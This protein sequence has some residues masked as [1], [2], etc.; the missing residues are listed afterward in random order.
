MNG[1]WTTG[2]VWWGVKEGAID[3]ASI[4]SDV[5]PEVKLKV[6]QIKVG[7]S[8]S[9]YQIWRG[10]MVDNMGKILLNQGEMANDKFLSGVNFYVAGVEGRVPGK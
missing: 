1:S 3:I 7:L 2:G 4:A 8:N 10:P 9:T 5:P 6:N